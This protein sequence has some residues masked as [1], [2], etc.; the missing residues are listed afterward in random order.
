[1][2]HSCKINVTTDSWICLIRVYKTPIYIVLA[3][4]LKHFFTWL[5]QIKEKEKQ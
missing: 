2:T 1:M 4:P 5:M 3:K